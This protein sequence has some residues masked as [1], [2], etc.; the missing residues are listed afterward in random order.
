MAKRDDTPENQQGRVAQVRAAYSIT[1][2]VQ[3]RIGLMLAGIFLA[4][5]VGVRRRRLRAERAPSLW[6]PIT[7][8]PFAVLLT[9]IF[10]G[11]RVEK[12][13]YSSLEGQLGPGRTRCPPCA[14]WTVD[15][16]VAVTRNQD[17]VH[18]VV[19]RPGIV[20]VAEGAPNRV[21]QPARQR[22][23]QARPGRSP[24]RRSTTSWSVTVRGRSRCAGLSGQ[25]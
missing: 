22:E 7:G 17:V 21:R 14:G 9:V 8:I 6:G 25:S 24:T 13:A 3:P 4:V 1:K 5:I 2:E 15:P 16:A 23:A 10:F 11:R 19:G 20:L 18:R 12:A